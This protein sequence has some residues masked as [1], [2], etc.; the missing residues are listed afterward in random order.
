MCIPFYIL[1]LIDLFVIHYMQC[2]TLFKLMDR[3]AMTTSRIHLEAATSSNNE[4]NKNG[5]ESFYNYL[6]SELKKHNE[7]TSINCY[8]NPLQITLSVY[9]ML[10]SNHRFYKSYNSHSYNNGNN[11][12]D[13]NISNIKSFMSDGSEIKNKNHN[14]ARPP[15]SSFQKASQLYKTS[16]V[17]ID[18]APPF[19]IDMLYSLPVTGC[20]QYLRLQGKKCDDRDGEKEIDKSIEKVLYLIRH[21]YPHLIFWLDLNSLLISAKFEFLRYG[22][23]LDL[24]KNQLCFNKACIQGDI[25]K[26]HESFIKDYVN[27]E[28]QWNNDV[29]FKIPQSFYSL[30][31][32]QDVIPTDI[33]LLPSELSLN[34]LSDTLSAMAASFENND[35][36]HLKWQ[37]V[38]C[39]WWH[40]YS[41]YQPLSFV[42]STLRPFVVNGVDLSIRYLSIY[43]YTFVLFVLLLADD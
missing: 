19:P 32:D 43:I 25:G 10:L 27:N 17:K 13:H 12:N 16:K 40:K 24:M 6:E 2:L 35:L 18:K 7:C 31:T 3:C 23:N 41:M 5:V 26:I 14:V 9:F 4:K 36:A 29:P 20:L 28:Q 30:I 22:L 33:Q 38:F 34:D 11:L 8:D 21:H 15:P 37:Y 39:Y 1:L 42:C